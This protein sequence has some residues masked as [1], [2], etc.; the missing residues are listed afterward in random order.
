MLYPWHKA[1]YADIGDPALQ[2]DPN[3]LYGAADHHQGPRER[4]ERAPN[5]Q[6]VW[7]RPEDVLLHHQATC[8]PQFGV[9]PS[10]ASTAAFFSLMT[11]RVECEAST[12]RCQR[13]HMRTQVLLR[14]QPDLAAGPYGGAGGYIEGASEGR[15]RRLGRRRGWR[16][17]ETV[18]TR[19]F[20]PNRLPAFVQPARA[21][22]APDEV[23]EGLPTPD[24]YIQQLDGQDCKWCGVLCHVLVLKD[25]TQGFVN[26]TKSDRRFF[27]TR[28][29]ELEDEGFIERVQV[30]HADRKR[31]PDKKVLCVRLMTNDPSQADGMLIDNEEIQGRF[32]R[33][34]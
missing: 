18:H 21:Q 16:G 6:D 30:A 10:V 5:R 2:T 12:A 11:H 7:L 9:S 32:P 19:P 14:P 13:E 31:F 3:D 17:H 28:L 15:R 24:A 27:R 34:S 8:G 1:L 26:P 4:R 20:R 25:T 23:A 29:R 33:L 22:V